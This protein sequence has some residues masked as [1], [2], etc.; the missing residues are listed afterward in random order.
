[1]ISNKNSVDKQEIVPS[2]VRRKLRDDKIRRMYFVDGYTYKQIA[3][4]EGHSET[5][6]RN[7][8]HN[9]VDN[10]N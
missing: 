2:K 7:A 5:T 8:I 6:I 1:M 3:H 10:K 9:K 4:K